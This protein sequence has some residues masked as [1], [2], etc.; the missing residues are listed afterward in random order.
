MNPRTLDIEDPAAVARRVAGLTE[1]LGRERVFINPD[2]GFGTFAE[3]PVATA[4]T[5]FQKL[6]CLSA[7][8]RM[9]R[10]R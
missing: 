5:A 1:L 8:A 4:E 7:A 10:D 3:R 9:V 2:C 6:R